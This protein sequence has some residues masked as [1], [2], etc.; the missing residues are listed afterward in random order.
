MWAFVTGGTES[1]PATAEDAEDLT[2]AGESDSTTDAGIE[3]E[4]DDLEEGLDQLLKES[5]TEL[6]A[7]E[8]EL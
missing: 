2:D 5:E 3:D 7:L 4:L 8:S 1:V 6:D